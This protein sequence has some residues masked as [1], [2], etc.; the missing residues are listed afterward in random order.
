VSC[1]YEE[2]IQVRIALTCHFLRRTCRP[3]IQKINEEV[4]QYSRIVCKEMIVIASSDKPLPRA[5]KGSVNKAASLMLY[6]K[7]IEDA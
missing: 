4:P 1:F 5:V 7:E 3:I 6:E 2:G